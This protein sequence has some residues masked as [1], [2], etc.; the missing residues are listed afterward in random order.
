MPPLTSTNAK[1]N[2]ANDLLVN[3]IQ[4]EILDLFIFY[5]NEFNT[6]N[7]KKKQQSYCACSVTSHHRH[8]SLS[9]SPTWQSAR[10]SACSVCDR[11]RRPSTYKDKQKKFTVKKIH[12]L[13]CCWRNKTRWQK[14][15]Y[16][17]EIPHESY[18]A[19]ISNR[20]A[21]DVDVREQWLLVRSERFAE[22]NYIIIF[23]RRY[24][25]LWSRN[26][27]KWQRKTKH[28]NKIAK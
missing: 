16:D 9:I 23:L 18:Q 6:D 13:C 4:T 17:D 11:E 2:G 27:G 24:T 21:A 5:N 15:I 7:A 25:P 26:E 20:I 28:E 1:N 10:R 19:A 3:Y 22:K 14:N 12:S 8:H